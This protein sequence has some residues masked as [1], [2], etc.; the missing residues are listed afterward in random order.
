MEAGAR[1]ADVAGHQREGDQA[2]GVVGPVGV[3]GD[4]HPPEDHGRLGRPEDAGHLADPLRRDATQ[5]R[6]RLGAVGLQGLGQALEALGP[7]PDIIPVDQ[8][9]FDQDMHHR[10]VEGDVGAGID[11]EEMVGMTGQVDLAG[12]D[13]DQRRSV[14]RRLLDERRRDRVVGRRVAAG[15]Q[16]DVRATHVA[17]DVGHGPG[18]D[19][20]QERGDRG[21]VTQP[22]AVVDVVRAEDGADQLLE[23]VRLLVAAL[24]GPEAGHGT[25]PVRVTDLRQP[26]RHQVQRLV[27]G[28]LAEGGHHL[29]VVDDA[30]GLAAPFALHVRGQRTL[31]VGVIAPDERRGQTLRVER[32]VEAVTPLHAQP[33]L[34]AGALATVGEDD[35]V[36]LGVHVVADRASDAAVGADGVDGLEL[37]PGPDRGGQLRVGERARRADRGALA[38]GDTRAVAHRDIHVEGDPRAVALAGPPDHVV[39]L[40]LVAGPDTSIAQDAG[41]VIDRDDRR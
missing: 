16:G 40:D 31:G 1:P 41:G 19:R 22:G 33:L 23:E 27:P 3:L 18:T 12:L 14:R 7:L 2:A 36:C 28:G 6:R 24:R 20:L 11:L 39:V 9:L 17:E 5:L 35:G 29:V 32:V 25:G 34:V 4:A 38:A 8:V 26:A 10:V 37:L 13:D 30:A 21:R 15:D